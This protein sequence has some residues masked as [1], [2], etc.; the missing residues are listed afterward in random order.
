MLR[1][2]ERTVRIT[3]VPPSADEQLR[4]RK[5]TYTTLMLIHLVGFGVGGALYEVARTTGWC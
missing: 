3:D 1:P 5:R 2:R 4:R